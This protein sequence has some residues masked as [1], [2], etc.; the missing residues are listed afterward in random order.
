MIYIQNM[1]KLVAHLENY[2]TSKK[3]KPTHNLKYESSQLIHYCATHVLEHKNKFHK[4]CNVSETRIRYPSAAYTSGTGLPHHSG[5]VK[6]ME[7][8]QTSVSQGMGCK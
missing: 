2:L 8:K 5:S 7:E 3:S 4:E 6:C 1:F